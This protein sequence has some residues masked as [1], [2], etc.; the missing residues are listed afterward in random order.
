MA[1]SGLLPVIT[2]VNDH[3]NGLIRNGSKKAQTIAGLDGARLL[4]SDDS[5][6]HAYIIPA[7]DYGVDNSMPPH[8][9]TRLGW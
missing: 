1:S 5:A 8:S 2:R 9:G 7:K 3:V 6:P 4:R